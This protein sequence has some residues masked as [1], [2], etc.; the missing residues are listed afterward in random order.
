MKE[1]AKH[2]ERAEEK[3]GAANLLF[4]NYDIYYEPSKEEAESVVEDAERFFGAD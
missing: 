2:L 3:L 4:E 1:W